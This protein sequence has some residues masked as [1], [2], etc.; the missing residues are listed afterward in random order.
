MK[1][2][3][4]LQLASV[5]VLGLLL[6]S[7][8]FPN[9]AKRLAVPSFTV[10]RIR[11]VEPELYSP[12]WYGHKM[13]TQGWDHRGRKRGK[14]FRLKAFAAD[15]YGPGLE[16][17]VMKP[18]GGTEWIDQRAAAI[19]TPDDEVSGMHLAFAEKERLRPR[20]R[21]E[22]GPDSEWVMVPDMR[23]T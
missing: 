12:E 16:P 3:D 18:A 17:I 13:A 23:S 19:P 1:R 14:D 7:W 8:L 21:M 15:S 6:P 20:W 11:R 10:P 9:P 4:L 5:S 22:L 2:R